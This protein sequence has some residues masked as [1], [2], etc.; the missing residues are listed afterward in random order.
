MRELSAEVSVVKEAAARIRAATKVRP[1]AVVEPP[2]VIV[3][4]KTEEGAA[5]LAPAPPPA[6]PR[7]GVLTSSELKSLQQ[8]AQG[9][10]VSFP[11]LK[12]L[13]KALEAV[14]AWKALAQEARGMRCPLARVL[15][16]I[17]SSE[18]LPA[19][20]PEVRIDN[21]HAHMLVSSPRK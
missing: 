4:A 5:P 17:A 20:C 16:L 6:N 19:F 8:Y 12:A 7:D 2:A 14:D 10:R 1:P 9:L 3:E 18:A 21:E 15:E 11:E 13:A